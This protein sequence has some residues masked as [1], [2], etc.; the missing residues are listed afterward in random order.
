VGVD[1]VSV[2]RVERLL[3]RYERARARLFTERE[4]AAF[5]GR[6]REGEHLAARFAAKEAIF[7]L[8]GRGIGDGLRWR[9][10]EVLTDERGRPSATL[11]GKAATWARE[12]GVTKV[13]IS[14]SHAEGLAIAQAA[15]LSS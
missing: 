2:E 5:A 4:A 11:S 3:E 1:L 13:E 8:L 10:V 15:A 14:L 6:R 12:A 7:K 9:D